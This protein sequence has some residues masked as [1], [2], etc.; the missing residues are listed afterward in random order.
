MLFPL[1]FAWPSSLQVQ[2]PVPTSLMTNTPFTIQ[3]NVTYPEQATIVRLHPLTFDNPGPRPDQYQVLIELAYQNGTA[4]RPIFWMEQY[5]KNGPLDT[6]SI[7]H[8]PSYILSNQTGTFKFKLTFTNID[9]W[10]DVV[11]NRNTILYSPPFEFIRSNSPIIKD[12]AFIR[13]G[14]LEDGKFVTLLYMPRVNA[15]QLLKFVNRGTTYYL[16]NHE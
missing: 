6:E 1:V 15:T 2:W 9:S 10:R 3:F 7:F 4:L 12:E 11:F 13:D 5:A 16:A 14:D 8:L